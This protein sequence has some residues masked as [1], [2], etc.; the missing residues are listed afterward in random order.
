MQVPVTKEPFPTF[1][2]RQVIAPFDRR[3]F[4]FEVRV[5][6]PEGEAETAFLA[7]LTIPPGNERRPDAPSFGGIHP[8]AVL[9]ATAVDVEGGQG[10]LQLEAAVRNTEHI[11]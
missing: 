6:G 8:G 11:G 2:T 1:R 9:I 5:I 3:A 7:A 4:G 10:R